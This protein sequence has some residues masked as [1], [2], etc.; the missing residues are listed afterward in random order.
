MGEDWIR[1]NGSWRLRFSYPGYNGQH[2][3]IQ[4]IAFNRY[5]KPQDSDGN[6][7]RWIGPD[8]TGISTTHNEGHWYANCH[9]GSVRGLGEVYDEGLRM[10][11]RLYWTGNI[12]PLRD[13]PIDLIFPNTKYDCGTGSGFPWSCAS[14][15]G[16]IW[17][18][19]AHALRNGVT[20]HELAHQLNYEFWDNKLPSG[21]GGSHSLSN[22]YNGGL[23]LTEGFANFMPFWVQVADRSTKPDSSKFDFD[24]E[25]PSACG[26]KKGQKGY[27]TKSGSQLPSGTSTTHTV[28]VSMSSGM[29]IR[30]APIA[31]YLANPPSSNGASWDIVYFLNI[32]KSNCSPGHEIYI[33]N[34][35]KQNHTDS[36]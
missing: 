13:K 18:I 7:Y 9:N 35:F 33:Q 5:F 28:M 11:S 30:G 22:C 3:R 20:Q 12:N 34:I 32:Y 1:F 29:C 17:L 16:K 15:A 14:K 23:A 19:P 31:L 26:D 36:R 21:A 2:L 4:Y 27:T 10:W 6:T 8:R 24:I 25:D